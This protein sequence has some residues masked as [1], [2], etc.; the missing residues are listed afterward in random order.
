MKKFL[1]VGTLHLWKT[2]HNDGGPASERISKTITAADFKDALRKARAFLA[3]TEKKYP[4][5]HSR[6]LDHCM[7]DFEKATV[8]LY[9]IG[10]TQ[11]LSL[12][13]ERP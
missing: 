10:R 11:H 9:E 6:P 8:V 2:V 7:T 1:L 12:K 4:Q 3:A 5:D 13:K